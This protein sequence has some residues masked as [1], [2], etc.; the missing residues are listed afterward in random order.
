MTLEINRPGGGTLTLD[1]TV[2]DPGELT[3]RPALPR[4]CYSAAH[5]VFK[6]SYADVPHTVESPGSAQEIADGIDWDA[7]LALRTRADRF[8]MGTAEAMDTAQRFELGWIGARELL[9]RT[10]QL[11]LENGFVGGASSDHRDHIDDVD[12]L[13]EA[14]LE[15]VGFVAEQG[16]L[17]IVLPQ[18]WMTA[19]NMGEEDYVRLYTRIA[20]HAGTPILVH[21]LGEVFHSGMRGY[22]PGT[23]IDRILDHDPAKIRGIKLSLLDAEYEESLRARIDPRGQVILTGDDYNFSR[24]MEGRSQESREIEPLDGRPMAGGDFSHALLGIFDAT[25]RPSSLALQRLGRGDVEGYRALMEPCEELGRVI[26]EAPVQ[27]YKS[28][29]AFLA[30]LNGLQDNSMLANHEERVRDADHYLRVV[31]VASRA[32]V[33]EN[34]S[35]AAERLDEY[36]ASQG[37]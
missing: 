10:G 28:G 13:G 11:R 6:A 22:F 2:L 24:L 17:P 3:E 16:G 33:L 8:G 18:P 36:L 30:W 29:I 35:L 32:G 26:F 27:R 5:V 12:D 20:D 14:I 34:A 9:R 21:W 4:R 25:V 31:E 15:Q 1:D 37:A 7:T 23:S 19:N